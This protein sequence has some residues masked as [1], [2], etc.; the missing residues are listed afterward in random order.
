MGKVTAKGIFIGGENAQRGSPPRLPA[1]G[2]EKP[3]K[4]RSE[5]KRK[6]KGGKGQGEKTFMVAKAQG[7]RKAIREVLKK[8]GGGGGTKEGGGDFDFSDEKKV[9]GVFL[10]QLLL[11]DKSKEG[12]VRKKARRGVRRA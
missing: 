9:G 5:E 4:R 8:K 7:E 11:A 1:W 12:V 3:K 6:T 10:H 2:K